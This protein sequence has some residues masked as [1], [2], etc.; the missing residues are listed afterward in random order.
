[1]LKGQT[2]ARG[3]TK[4]GRPIDM[5]AASVQ[6]LIDGGVMFCG[7][8]DQVYQ[9]I[10]D[11][12]EHTGGMGNLLAMAHAGFLPPADTI[13]NLTLLAK[14]VMPRLQEYRQPGVERMAAE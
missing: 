8:P 11:F 6:D 12:C 9:Q 7:T 4:D 13:D 5:K 14:E 2:P 1:M 3:A 10:V